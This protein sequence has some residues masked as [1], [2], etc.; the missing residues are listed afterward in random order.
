MYICRLFTSGGKLH[1]EFEDEDLET[2]LENAKEHIEA[3][4]TIVLIG[5]KDHVGDYELL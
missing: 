4:D 2:C 3:N 1:G 5:D